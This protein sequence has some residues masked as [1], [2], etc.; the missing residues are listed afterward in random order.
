MKVAVIPA[1]GGSK[2]VEGKNI[3]SLAGRPLIT[4]VIATL[5]ESE[6]FNSIVVSTDD[7]EIALIAQSAGARVPFV[8]P[9]ELAEDHS[10]TDEV[11]VHALD[12]LKANEQLPTFC[13]CVYPTSVLITKEM[14]I[15]SFDLIETR[16]AHS[17]AVVK[18]YQH[19]IFRAL[20][21]D[22]EQRIKYI[23]PENRVVRTQDLA[24]TYY[25]AGQFYWISAESYLKD[26]RLLS[27]NSLGY[28]IPSDKTWDIDN[29]EDFAIVNRMFPRK[30]KR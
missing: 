1:R 15:D 7:A 17:V 29:E 11:L 27:N 10:S 6:L 21:K 28:V 22:H 13:C 20:S 19:P 30:D 9:A 3:R 24:E 2:R 12:W 5:I 25:D 14:L 23:W 18:K 8:R 4:W 16:H 26:P